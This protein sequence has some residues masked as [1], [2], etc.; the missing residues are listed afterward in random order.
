MERVKVLKGE[1]QRDILCIN[2]CAMPGRKS[3][4]SVRKRITVGDNAAEIK[5][6]LKR[7]V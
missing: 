5:P 7:C 4:H 6:C 3:Q 2:E 1:R